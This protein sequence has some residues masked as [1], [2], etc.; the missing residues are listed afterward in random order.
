MEESKDIKH[1]LQESSKDKMGGH[2]E[3]T[4]QMIHHKTLPHELKLK[5]TLPM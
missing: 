2:S 1:T 4:E 5:F 3:N